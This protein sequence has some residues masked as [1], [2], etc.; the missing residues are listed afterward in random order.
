MQGIP[1]CQ[2]VPAGLYVFQVGVAI[3]ISPAVGRCPALSMGEYFSRN[4]I[5][6]G[7]VMGM[8]NGVDNQF[9]FGFGF[10]DSVCL[11]GY[12]AFVVNQVQA[13]F[14]GRQV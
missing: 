12:A 7:I 13:V 10:L 2:S 8:D 11:S 6:L 9:E 5:A 14:S 1:L 4:G 3:A